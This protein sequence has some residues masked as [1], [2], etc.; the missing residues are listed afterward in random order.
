MGG[1]PEQLNST[2]LYQILTCPPYGCS[3]QLLAEEVGR[4]VIHLGKPHSSE[5]VSKRRCWLTA[6]TRAT[7]TRLRDLPIRSPSCVDGARLPGRHVRCHPGN[8]GGLGRV[9]QFSG[10]GVPSQPRPI[11]PV[12]KYDTSLVAQSG[13][14][15]TDPCMSSSTVKIQPPTAERICFVHSYNDTHS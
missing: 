1:R 7:A 8:P 5:R 6:P 14:C 4:D 13:T 3:E 10:T 11:R 15:R 12:L 2:S 9:G